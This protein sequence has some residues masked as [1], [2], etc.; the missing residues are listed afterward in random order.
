MS[1]DQVQEAV[2]SVEFTEWMAFYRLEAELMGGG[3]KDRPTEDETVARLRGWAAAHN[4]RLQ[5][6]R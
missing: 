2:S 1:V 6:G 3:A 4:A 5:A